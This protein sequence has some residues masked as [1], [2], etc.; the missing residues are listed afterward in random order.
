MGGMYMEKIA[1]YNRK[2][3][4]GKTTTSFNLAGCLDYVEHKRVL[5]VDCD[6]QSNITTSLMLY[7][8]D[9]YLSDSSTIYDLFMG[10]QKDCGKYLQ[11]VK[12]PDRKG[13]LT[14]STRISILPGTKDLDKISTENMYIL[15]DFL[16]LY[17]DKF[18]YCIIDS[19]PS[20][21]DI[22]INIL[23]AADYIIIPSC[24]GR[25]SVNGYGMVID[26]VNAM[27][28]NGYNMNLQVLGVLMNKVG[29][30]RILEKYYSS[31]W[32][33]EYDSG[34]SFKAQIR[35]SADVGNAYELGKPIHYYKRTC[36]VAHDYEE[37]SKEIINRIEKKAN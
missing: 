32:S 11:S 28:T 30:R 35:D 34:N 26:E 20:L 7:R 14:V 18:D 17:D 21:T 16:E 37:L 13:E 19:P 5:I 10:T 24:A 33:N 9:D 8:E 15:K 22:T 25:D 27:K 3:G 23:C 1:I 12:F 31:L 2:G 29:R 4:V 6:P 36:D